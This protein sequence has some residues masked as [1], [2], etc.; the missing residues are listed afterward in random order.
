LQIRD[1]DT[2]IVWE[3]GTWSYPV[4]SEQ[5]QIRYEENEYGYTSAKWI[6]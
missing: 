4:K 2:N 5:I 3:G 1:T 6:Q